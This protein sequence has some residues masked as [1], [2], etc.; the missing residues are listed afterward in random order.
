MASISELFDSIT[1]F[2][3]LKELVVVEPYE[4]S[5]T[6]EAQQLLSMPHL[7]RA[8]EFV[9]SLKSIDESWATNDCVLIGP[10]GKEVLPLYG[11]G[12]CYAVEAGFGEWA[13][14]SGLF[15]RTNTGNATVVI[16]GL[17]YPSPYGAG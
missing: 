13:D 16:C 17:S 9:I 12:D 8:R 10:R 5:L 6:T 1:S 7:H 4:V 11:V 14:V 2:L 15:G 3:K